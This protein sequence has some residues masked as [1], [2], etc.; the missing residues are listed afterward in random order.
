M[1]S[2]IAM[3]NRIRQVCGDPWDVEAPA[4]VV[5]AISGAGCIGKSTRASQLAILLGE[6]SCQAVSLDA[7]ML[8]RRL[9]PGLTGYDPRRYEL[10]KA[11]EQLSELIRRGKKLLLRQYNRRTH[12]RDLPQIVEPKPTIIIEGALAL[13][14]E[15]HDLA[16]IHVFLDADREVQFLLRK[17]REE[18]DF[19]SGPS[20][21]VERL[22]RY[23]HDYL[24]Y[25][26]PQRERAEIVACVDSDYRLTLPDSGARSASSGTSSQRG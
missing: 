8:P 13:R 6:S 21:I 1:D 22:A 19:G 15:L 18:K 3:L 12:E 16:R 25:V 2:A 24:R 26:L 23:Y 7:Y 14:P 5:I 9:A 11:R 4:S 17:R 20:Q 10:D